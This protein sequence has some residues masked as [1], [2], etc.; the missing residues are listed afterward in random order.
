VTIWERSITD[1]QNPCVTAVVK[2]FDHASSPAEIMERKMLLSFGPKLFFRVSASAWLLLAILLA[3]TLLKLNH[4]GHSNPRNWDEVFH[5]I[6]ARNFLKHPFTPMLNDRQ[7]IPASAADWYNAGVWLHKPPLAM[8]QIAISYAIFGVDTFALRLPSVLLST[9]AVWLTFLIARRLLDESAALVAAALQ[10]FAPAIVMLVQG[11][12]FADHVDVSLLFYSELAIYFLVRA[13]DSGK[14]F[15]ALFCG[16]A[17]GLALLSKAYPGLIVAG[18]AVVALLLPVVRVAEPGQWRFRSRHLLIFFVSALLTILPWTLWAWI[19]WPHEFV[20]ENFEQL[21]H[22]TD[23]V[24]QWGAPWDRL[25]FDYA[26]RVFH[27]YYPLM[28]ASLIVAILRAGRH[29][30]RLWIVIAWTLGTFIPHA[31]T[32]TKTPTATLLGWPAGWMLVGWL[33]SRAIR[34]DWLALGT[35]SSA[36]VLALVFARRDGIP[37]VGYG[38]PDRHGFGIIMRQH[39]WVSKQAICSLV[40][41][42]TLTALVGFSRLGVRYVRTPLCVMATIAMT[43]LAV[44]WWDQSRPVGYA[45]AAFRVTQLDAENPTACAIGR[46]AH[47]L[48]PEAVLIVDELDRMQNKQIEFFAD[49]TCYPMSSSTLVPDMTRTIVNHGG[50]PYLVSPK[51]LPLRCLFVDPTGKQSLYDCSVDKTMS[52][53]TRQ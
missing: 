31:L 41:G 42:G 4:L 36:M 20:Y 22:A 44:R 21:R 12:S 45:V 5:A 1:Q 47:A 7:F 35:W 37:S 39:L 24:E 9:A 50:H 8:W 18:I 16:V 51:S 33:I 52:S 23:D 43:V 3:S 32:E 25:V 28:L 29:D 40:F 49:R 19:H 10:A 26:I 48:P 13:V 27:V 34:G 53:G 38:Y 15:D 17:Q 6:V 46:F 30:A 14:D 11:Y 2:E